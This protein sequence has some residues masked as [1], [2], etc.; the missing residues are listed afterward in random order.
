MLRR[1]IDFIAVFFIGVV[2]F[3]ISRAPSV[4]LPVQVNTVRFENASIRLQNAS[5]RLQTAS[6]RLQTAASR[7][8]CP[9]KRDFLAGLADFLNQ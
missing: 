6:E 7:E 2:M 8:S 9:M 1:H 3:A 4:T 5:M